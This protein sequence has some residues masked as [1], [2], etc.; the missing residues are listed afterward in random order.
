MALTAIVPESDFEALDETLKT[1]YVQNTDTKEYYLDVDNAD[2]LAVNLQTE[3]T[4][5]ADNNQKLVDQLAKAREEAA[6]LAA[7]AKAAAD[8]AEGEPDHSVKLAEY[9]AKIASYE[10]SL[11]TE[12][13][14]RQTVARQAAVSAREAD[15]ERVLNK[16]QMFPTSAANLREATEVVQNEDGTCSV[17]VVGPDGKPL[18]Q[19]GQAVT[20][21]TLVAG[22]QND[23]AHATLFAANGVGGTGAP[24]R[25]NGGRGASKI[26]KRS[27]WE[28][29]T[30]AESTAFIGEGGIVVPD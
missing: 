3:K 11:K 8:K 28:S 22:W 6:Q 25:M 14:Q 20:L 26:L 13:E 5:L 2:R 24:A 29:M 27:Q 19:A 12:R 1:F 15:I 21:E 9:E 30:A 4:K 10:E 18:M 7:K 17:Q 23:P 16:F